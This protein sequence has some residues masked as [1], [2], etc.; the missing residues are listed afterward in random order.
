MNIAP[1]RQGKKNLTDLVIG[2]CICKNFT[3]YR[4]L[5]ITNS[6]DTALNISGAIEDNLKNSNLSEGGLVAI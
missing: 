1:R 3:I 5:Q 2:G 6:N 4:F